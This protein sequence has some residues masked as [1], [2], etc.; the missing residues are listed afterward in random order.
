MN[1]KKLRQIFMLGFLLLGG[2][3]NKGDLYLPEEGKSNEAPASIEGE[4]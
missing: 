3:G 4:Q 2:C 1:F